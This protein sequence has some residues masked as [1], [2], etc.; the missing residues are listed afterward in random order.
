[1]YLPVSKCK[2]LVEYL[3]TNSIRNLDHDVADI[4]TLPTSMDEAQRIDPEF[5]YMSNSPHGFCPIDNSEGYVTHEV[6][7]EYVH[8]FRA[9]V[10]HAIPIAKLRNVNVVACYFIKIDQ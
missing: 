2:D 7:Q 9:A 8:L 3:K 10:K 6:E 1:M 4:I 5:E